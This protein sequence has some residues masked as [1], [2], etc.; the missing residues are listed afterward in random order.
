MNLLAIDTSSPACTAGVLAGER[1]VERY[2]VKPREH[3]RILLPMVHAVLDESGVG[4]ADLDAVAL[5]NGPGSFIGMRIGASVAQGLAFAANIDIVPVSSMEA[6][7]CRAGE[8]GDEVVV[9]QDAHM[10]QVYLGRYRIGEDGLPEVSEPERLYPTGEGAPVVDAPAIAAG[11]GFERYPELLADPCERLSFR[12]ECL[13]PHAVDVLALAAASVRNGG[14]I[15]PDALE[16]RY[17]REDV[18]AR[19]GRTLSP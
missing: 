15:A 17:L 12:P 7:A 16:P 3:T 13:Y 18:A 9:T 19:A 2:T 6:V 14:G 5:G 11:A 4:I 10:S 1:L 8:A